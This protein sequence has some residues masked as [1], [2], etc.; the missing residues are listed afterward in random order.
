[1]D[2]RL[3]EKT[4]FTIP[5]FS[6]MPA[7]ELA[8]SKTKEAEIRFVEA[9]VVNAATYSDLEFTFNEGYRECKTHLS[10]IMYRIAMTNKVLRKLKSQYLIDEYADFLKESKLK[11]STMTKEAFLNTKQDYVDALDH[12]DLMKAVECFIENKIKVFENVCRY[13]RK[14][15]EIQKI[16]GQIIDSNK[17]VR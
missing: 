16:S 14:E 13:M 10:A 17:Y 12:L 1:V 11:D 8:L 15:M 7:L 2:L 4:S 3:G 6:K 9:R 5:E